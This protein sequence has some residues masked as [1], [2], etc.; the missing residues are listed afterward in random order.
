VAE[1]FDY[2]ERAKS[3]AL[4]DLL[5]RNLSGRVQPHD[6][7]GQK[8][9]SDLKRLREELNWYYN[10][11]HD[12]NPDAP[13]RSPAVMAR[14][15]HEINH[16]ERQANELMHQMRV[17]YTHYLSLRLVQSSSLQAIRACLPPD[18]LLV[19][20]YIA[21]DAVLAF[22]L[23]QDSLGVYRNLMS[24]AQIEQWLDAFQFQI[25]KFRYGRDYVGRHQSTLRAGVDRSLKALYE[26]L[27]APLAHELGEG[28]PLVFIPHGLL[29]YIPFHALYD[30]ERYLVETHLVYSA[31][32]ASVLKLCCERNTN[33]GGPALLL[34]VTDP[35]IPHVIEEVN[36]ISYLLGQVSLYT[37]AQATLER[38]QTDAGRSKLIHIASH[39]LFRAD[40]PLFSALRLA[41]GWLNVNDIYDLKL[42]A[43]LV[44]LS[45]C[46][47]GM[48]LVAEGDEL[49]GLSRA[50]FYAGA[51]SLVVSL[52]A[53]SDESTALL[54]K[55]FYEA[56]QSGYCVAESLRCAQLG[57][58]DRSPHPYYWA[59]FNVTGD[60]QVTL[61]GPSSQLSRL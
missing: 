6:E 18:G 22:T 26:G 14:A 17:R 49:I 55:Q 3:R 45:G 19:E 40:N 1:A 21:R 44:T 4:V 56:L 41:D 24:R 28:R 16:L 35:S 43:R 36:G 61:G 58:M 39:G 32:S 52:W 23:S 12:H 46:E 10:R 51:P 15:W 31:P 60:G 37:G 27:V 9:V 29:H 34:G 38:L 53:V 48:G 2:V 20:Y 50:F 33:D 59:S 13:Q 57:L 25:H 47:T 8:L 54:M 11:L 42:K 30:G 5:A 7:A